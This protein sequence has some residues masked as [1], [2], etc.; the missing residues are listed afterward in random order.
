MARTIAEVRARYGY[1]PPEPQLPTP[2]VDFEKEEEPSSA[3]NVRIGART[4]QQVRELYGYTPPPKP[5]VQ[6]S[7]F[8]P[9]ETRSGFL[10]HIGKSIQDSW[11]YINIALDPIGEDD[12]Q[13]T[14]RRIAEVSRRQQEVV[15]SASHQYIMD[16]FSR[17]GKDIEEAKGIVDTS[18]EVLDATVKSIWAALTN[19]LGVAEFGAGQVGNTLATVSGMFAGAVVGG[20]STSWTGPGAIA[21]V[22][23]G[24]RAGAGLAGG[25][26]ET[27]A[28]VIEALH[29]RGI[30]TTNQQAVFKALTDPEIARDLYKKGLTKGVVIG[31]TDAL[32]MGLSKMPFTKPGRALNKEI[33]KKGLDLRKKE[34][35]LEVARLHDAGADVVVNAFKKYADITAKGVPFRQSLKAFGIETVGE[36]T[37][38]ALG[39]LA[40]FGETSFEDIAS[41]MLGS[42]TQS[43]VQTGV[44]KSLEKAKSRYTEATREAARHRVQRGADG[45]ASGVEPSEVNADLSRRAAGVAE[46]VG[47]ATPDIEAWERVVSEAESDESREA[48]RYQLENIAGLSE[49]SASLR[50]ALD[51][52]FPEGAPVWAAL[53]KE[54]QAILRSGGQ[55]DHVVL[56]SLNRNTVTSKEGQD[57]VLLKVPTSSVIMRGDWNKMEVLLSKENLSISTP[58]APAPT[59]TAPVETTTTPFADQLDATATQLE[60]EEQNLELDR[61]V[62]IGELEA[63]ATGRSATD[64]KADAREATKRAQRKLGS[65]KDP[66]EYATVADLQAAVDRVKVPLYAGQRKKRVPLAGALSNYRKALANPS[67]TATVNA[68]LA[69]TG[70]KITKRKD[71]VHIVPIVRNPDNNLRVSNTGNR[72]VGQSTV[73]DY[74]F[75]IKE[76]QAATTPPSTVRQREALQREA[77]KVRGRKEPKANVQSAI[78]HVERSFVTRKDGRTT[79]DAEGLEAFVAETNA[80]ETWS[81]A[82]KAAFNRHVKELRKEEALSQRKR[83]SA[84]LKGRATV[85]DTA[86]V[87]P[88]ESLLSIFKRSGRRK[89][90]QRAGS[91][92]RTK[93]GKDGLLQQIAGVFVQG[94]SGA[95]AQGARRDPATILTLSSKADNAKIADV[96]ALA[97]QYIFMR[98]SISWMRPDN[99]LDINA[100]GVSL[101]V[102]LRFSKSFTGANVRESQLLGQIRSIFGDDVNYT[103]IGDFEVVISSDRLSNLQ[104]ARRLGRLRA[105]RNDIKKSELFTAQTQTFTHDW[106]ADPSGASIREQIRK[107]GFADLLTYL[108]DRR[109]AYL[110]IAEEVGATETAQ[111]RPEARAPPEETEADLEHT[112]VIEDASGASFSLAP[113]EG[114]EEVVRGW[115]LFNQRKDGSLGPLFINRRQRVAIGEWLPAEEHPTKGFAFRPH[116]HATAVPKA[117]HMKE[118]KTSGLFRGWR[119]VEWRGITPMERPEK[120]GGTWFLA[121]EL[122]V[123]PEEEVEQSSPAFSLDDAESPSLGERKSRRVGEGKST[124]DKTTRHLEDLEKTIPVSERTARA[125]TGKRTTVDGNSFLG[126]NLEQEG[127]GILGVTQEDLNKVWED[128]VDGTSNS[129]AARQIIAKLKMAPKDAAFWDAALRLPNRAR[130]WYEVSAESFEE[131][132]HVSKDDLK[133]FIAIVSATSPQAN[134][135]VNMKRAVGVFSQYMSG[136]PIDMD[137]TIPQNVREALQYGT[138]S[139][140]KTGSFAATMQYVLG[141]ENTPPLSTNDRQVASS[142]GVTGDAI[143][144]NPILYETLSRFYINLRDTLNAQLPPGAELFETWQLQALGW[145]E[146]RAISDKTDS[147]R[148]QTDDY[149]SALQSEEKGKRRGVIPILKD[150]GI[151]RNDFLTEDDFS[152]GEIPSA[153]SGT[154]DRYRSKQKLTIEIGSPFSEVQAEAKALAQQAFKN[155]PVAAREFLETFTSVLYASGRGVTNPFNEL[156]SAITGKKTTLTRLQAPTSESPFDVA[157]TYEGEVSPNVRVPMPENMSDED[158]RVAM[159]VI[160]RAW[161]QAAMA[162]SNFQ[163]KGKAEGVD[164][165]SVFVETT[166]NLGAT[167]RLFEDFS[168]ALPDGHE[169]IIERWPNG[170]MLHVTPDFTDDG[171]VSLDVDSIIEEADKAFGSAVKVAPTVFSG[172]YIEAVDYGKI[173]SRFRNKLRQDVRK[174]E[175]IK[176]GDTTVSKRDYRTLQ[177]KAEASAR[178]L[179]NLDSAIRKANELQQEFEKRQAKWVKKYRERLS[180]DKN[181]RLPVESLLPVE[182]P[183]IRGLSVLEVRKALSKRFGGKGISSLEAQGILKIVQSVEDVPPGLITDAD[184]VRRARALFDPKT[185]TA[186]IIA[187]RVHEGNA[188]KILLHEVGT[189]Y[190]LKRM[191]GNRGYAQLM[192]DLIEGRETTFKPWFD[193]VKKNYGR[194]LDPNSEIFAEEVLAHIAEDTSDTTLSFRQRLWRQIRIFLNQVFGTSLPQRELTPQEVGYVIQGSLRRA[195]AGKLPRHMLIEPGD[196]RFGWHRNAMGAFP[197]FDQPTR[198]VTD[199]HRIYE[200]ASSTDR[201]IPQ[202]E[203]RRLRRNMDGMLKVSENAFKKKYR[204]VDVHFPIVSQGASI[205]SRYVIFRNTKT[206]TELVIR[207]SNHPKDIFAAASAFP[208]ISFNKGHQQD[209]VDLTEIDAAVKLLSEGKLEGM[210]GLQFQFEH[211][212]GD[213]VVGISKANLKRFSYRQFKEILGKKKPVDLRRLQS[214]EEIEELD[215]LHILRDDGPLFSIEPDDP[216]VTLRGKLGGTPRRSVAEWIGEARHRIAL[217]AVQGAVD[218]FRPIKAMGGEDATRAWQMMHLS[219]SSHGMMHA[220]LHYGAPKSVYRNGQ[221]D[222]YS[223][224]EKGR[225]LLDVLKA[226]DGNANDFFEYLVAQR[227]KKLAE[228]TAEFP[229]GRENFFTTDE[230]K[231]GLDKVNGPPINGRSRSL[232]FAETM[233][234]VSRFQKSVLDMAQEAGVLGKEQREALQTDF[235]IPFY[236]EFQDKKGVSGPTAAH[237]FVNIKN[238]I[239][240]LRGSEVPVNDV[241]HNMMMNWGALMGAAM[242]NRAGVAAMLA[243]VKSGAANKVTDKKEVAQLQF[244]KKFSKRDKLAN[245]VYTLEKGEKVWYEVTDPLVFNAMSHMAWGG[246]DSAVLRT[247]ATF[248]RWMTI[249][250]TA[251]P[252]FKIRNLIR[253][254]VHAIAV[255]KLDYNFFGNST[256]GYSTLANDNL[257]THRMMM[258]GATFQFGFANDDPQALRRMLDMYGEGRILNTSVKLR[259]FSNKFFGWYQDMGNRMENANRASLYMQRVEEV[260]HMQASFESRDLLNFSSHGR[261]VATQWIIGMI[262]FLNARLQ[263]LDKLARSTE[264]GSRARLVSVVGAITL[265]SILLR[266]SYEG[267]EDYEDLEEWEK[268]TYWPIKIPGTKDFFWI[269]KPFEIGAIA[270]VG[271]RITENFI[272]DMNE[273]QFGGGAGG[274]F[275]WISKYT[276][277]R[278]G[279][280][281]QDQ[282]AFDARPQI[283]K[284]MLEVYRNKDAFTDRPIENISWQIANK[285]KH[286]RVRAYT[287]EFAKKASWMHGELLDALGRKD[288]DT[289]L[290]PVQVDH[291]IKGYFG[292]L[293]ATITGSFDVLTDPRFSP[294]AE[295]EPMPPSMRIS[296]L[297]TWLPIGSFIRQNPRGSNKYTTL[298]YEQ[299]NEIQKLKSAYDDYKRDNLVDDMA[300]LVAE[301]GDTLR[302]WKRY[303]DT[304][305]YFSKLN[306]VMKDVHEDP[307]MSPEKKR[308]R[309]DSINQRKVDIAK[310]VVLFR[311]AQFD[312]DTRAEHG[313]YPS[314][315][316]GK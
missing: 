291:L 290:S 178:R 30:D 64:V 70:Y 26:V 12:P 53:S 303:N 250:V 187:D 294:L 56:G 119:Q 69:P 273:G 34:D 266:M 277:Q 51:E 57:V 309:I 94:K 92:I 301:D 76:E 223:V 29:H 215:S 244:G 31:V 121:N 286:R 77:Q 287:S 289:H 2:S 58:A 207:M 50:A 193:R 214:V 145:V 95:V 82:D 135:I 162:H 200:I 229:E 166:D 262:P 298:F 205:E 281:I 134:P 299:M 255:G 159:A 172:D 138:L 206:G 202:H 108:D 133:R 75:W 78:A 151:I 45:G 65:T 221:F 129:E 16:V 183:A 99:T 256:K 184:A 177:T 253:D 227:A 41:E 186:Y 267:D 5:T 182:K 71:G 11:D 23:I 239:R 100:E 302:W 46:R 254:S 283:F 28:A 164:T 233:L 37:G 263:G 6:Q 22:G 144:Q 230:I 308:E 220:M 310:S 60:R 222:W 163:D 126:L 296:D 80:I 209:V 269:P 84:P 101:G 102:H 306:K 142:F 9:T 160:G 307:D 87:G 312:E 81:K 195:M 236:R 167:G 280:I 24:A 59:E 198:Q 212:F 48:L 226:L 39:G 150:A 282:L 175:A 143:A 179:D 103:R 42:T 284:P 174:F 10:A 247:F 93:T 161:K 120:Q 123:L 132:L 173:I 113:E 118:G 188:A 74:L 124:E 311:A 293:G 252:A 270:T 67:R 13:D 104:L 36:G 261:W 153:L 148:G 62:E 141:L 136:N 88:L 89:F 72:E 300:R 17:E 4:I 264:K 185:N 63:Q 146:E 240:R 260:G 246:V 86:S 19:P 147:T 248:K 27:G 259:K 271:E 288:T 315:V 20:V 201:E 54:D 190:G 305:R 274:G 268:N 216:A 265:A 228:P 33:S 237:D 258:G 225:G 83:P 117:P 243:A 8:T 110:D 14:A 3:E 249:G 155:N 314:K 1:T 152:G 32:F 279:E 112:V 275:G 157:G 211:G 218:A 181:K 66:D 210:N 194:R 90:Q 154:L 213:G 85:V 238:V 106:N 276:W 189:H 107:A 158:I 251:S 224:D 204:D 131:L 297:R 18:Y 52:F 55:L 156:V 68:V 114:G 109:G 98:P 278:I 25:T 313:N 38:E 115:K 304:R 231:A 180:P 111:L 44:V 7:S 192:A 197:E 40:A 79:V 21:G 125:S 97:T 176:D 285:P 137:L 199:R 130:Y 127:Q 196:V 242:K 43:A 232:V 122:R 15:R 191:L 61:E 295:G 257:V 245:F 171:P 116:W 203:R 91:V 272:R 73:D 165:H 139:G 219:E 292:W 169:V 170:Y 168:S 316:F 140:L 47:E 149:L 35:W 234:K 241:L 217:K 105:K 235:Y 128:S 208:F 49:H 96:Y